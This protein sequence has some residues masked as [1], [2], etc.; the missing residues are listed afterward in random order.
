MSGTGS[1]HLERADAAADHWRCNVQ[2]RDPSGLLDRRCSA[3]SSSATKDVDPLPPRWL[4]PAR[5]GRG[6]G[7]CVGASTA[8]P[9][10]TF[11]CCTRDLCL[12]LR[13]APALHT[14][15]GFTVLTPVSVPRSERSTT[16]ALPSTAPSRRLPVRLRHV[17]QLPLLHMAWTPTP[18]RCARGAR[19]CCQ[20]R[21]RPWRCTSRATRCSPNLIRPK[22]PPRPRPPPPPEDRAESWWQDA[23]NSRRIRGSPP[24][25]GPERSAHRKYIS[26]A[27]APVRSAAAIYFMLARNLPMRAHGSG[28]RPGQRQS[29]VP[30]A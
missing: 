17:M 4:G 29:A 13:C 30:S 20:R 5:P 21:R 22:A 23:G 12:S 27:S 15:A 25:A 14:T 6:R 2:L 10:S 19:P 18:R 1:L 3:M 28:L 9:A 24:R 7:A 8:V 16:A 11:T 26:H